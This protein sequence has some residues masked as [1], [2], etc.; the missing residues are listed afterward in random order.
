MSDVRPDGSCRASYRCRTERG[1]GHRLCPG[2]PGRALAVNDFHADRAM[3]VAEEI[4]QAGGQ[5]VA[6]PFDV[7]DLAAVT[8][9]FDEAT[10]RLGSRGCALSITRYRGL[11]A[12]CMAGIVA[13]G[14]NHTIGTNSISS[15]RS[16]SSCSVRG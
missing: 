14:S 13:V 12:V 3:R 2:R 5:A 4:N 9:G 6:I 7:T 11:L 16:S 1:R 10:A 15:S 8:A